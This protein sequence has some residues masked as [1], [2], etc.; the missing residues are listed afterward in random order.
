MTPTDQPRQRSFV[1]EMEAR[2]YVLE[3]LTGWDQLTGD[4]AAVWGEPYGPAEEWELDIRDRDIDGPHGA[5]GVRVY[6]PSAPGRDRACLVWLHGG[7]FVAGD[8]DMPEAHEVARGVAGR[9]DAVVVSVDYRLCPPLPD[10]SGAPVE[11]A[12]AGPAV[13]F[14]VAHDEAVRAYRW[15]REHADELGVDPER[16]SLGGASAGANLAAGAALHLVDEHEPPWQVLLAYP[17]VHP[18]LP[19]PSPELVD[20]VAGTPEVLRFPPELCVEMNENYLGGPLRDMSPY[21][22]AGLSDD[23]AGFP[24][25]L[26]DND[27]F[28]D[29]RSSGERFAQQL[30]DAAVPVELVTTAGVPHG[31]L[32]NVGFGPTQRSLDRMAARLRW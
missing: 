20:A 21:A 16:V 17:V 12:D 5:I 26:I 15:T 13:R 3:G 1:P 27:E 32:N 19:E 28:D 7:G 22:F 9:A 25:T 2:R 18:V 6:T 10:S 23:L 31:H 30:V 4:R 14:P 29:L 11:A 24:P 8:L